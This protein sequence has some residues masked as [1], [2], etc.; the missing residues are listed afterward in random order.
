MERGAMNS[1]SWSVRCRRNGSNKGEGHG[2]RLSGDSGDRD[3]VG[4]R[5]EHQKE[6]VV[7]RAPLP[8]SVLLPL[9]VVLIP[10]V[11]PSRLNIQ[12][13]KDSVVK[14]KRAPP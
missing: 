14:G 8:D 4:Q 5:G 6:R 13:G 9:L 7:P 1:D 3:H 11:Q 2:E 10:V 12:S